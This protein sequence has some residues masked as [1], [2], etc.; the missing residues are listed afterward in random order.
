MRHHS[1]SIILLLAAAQIL[2]G[3]PLYQEA[4]LINLQNETVPGLV[5]DQGEIQNSSVCLFRSGKE[6]DP[7]EYLP[8]SIL[9]YGFTGGARY[10]S[11]TVKLAGIP[12]QIF[13]ECLVKGNASL[14]YLRNDSVECYLLD[15]GGAGF[16][17][18]I[19]G[20]VYDLRMLKAIFSDCLE[21][22]ADI[23][24]SRLNHRSLIRITC[25]YNN[26]GGQAGDCTTYGSPS[27]M[28]LRIAPVVGYS[29][30]QYRVSGEEPF[31]SFDFDPVYVPAFGLWLDLGLSRLGPHLSF[32]LGAEA[33]AKSEYYTEYGDLSQLGLTDFY[34]YVHMQG[35]AA[36][37]FAG[38]TWH[39]TRNRIRPV[40]GGGLLLQK[41]IRPAFWYD[42]EMVTGPI[43]LT[44]EW[45]TGLAS[46]LFYGAYVRAGIETDLKGKHIL[47]AGIR[48]GTLITNPETIAG[49][50]NGIA[51]QI[52]LRSVMVPLT[53]QLG[54]FF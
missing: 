18:L 23:D 49:L 45:Q 39:F 11:K 37:M 40:L 51:D 3:Q 31:D 27:R 12:K 52:R 54:F 36:R 2:T 41:L 35:T 21:V 17:T 43:V 46:S 4:Y 14:Y 47:T 33:S 22:Q 50:N 5:A 16:Y 25:Q 28:R 10:E 42:R 19:P 32:Q 34:Y 44:D 48:G 24:R 53:F 26:C 8:G 38:A 6:A 7:V 29:M 9:A 1:L 15:K 20:S 13:A 30:E